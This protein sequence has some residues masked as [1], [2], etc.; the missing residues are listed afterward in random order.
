MTENEKKK[1]LKDFGKVEQDLELIREEMARLKSLAEKITASLSDIP[2]GGGAVDKI[3]MYAE[4][5]EE[6]EKRYGEFIKKEI[7]NSERIM[8]ALEKLPP[9]HR[10]VLILHYVQGLPIWKTAQKI[11]Y[12]ER[13][14][15]YYITMALKMLQL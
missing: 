3:Q 12:S 6:L 1:L 15:K 11:N 5:M 8:E 13:M 14:T 4:K 7:E 2:G 10:Q 9:V